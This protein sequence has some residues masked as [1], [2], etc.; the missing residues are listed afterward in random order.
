[1]KAFIQILKWRSLQ[2]PFMNG[3]AEISSVCSFR[4]PIYFK[5]KAF[6]MTS[7]A[8]PTYSLVETVDMTDW[9]ICEV[10]SDICLDS[11]IDCILCLP[12]LD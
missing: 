6:K 4:K 1:M 7:L 3:W 10:T 2:V 9:V 12:N 5:C 11:C 8:L